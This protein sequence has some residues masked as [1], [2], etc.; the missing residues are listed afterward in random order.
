MDCGPSVLNWK[1]T[2]HCP[3]SPSGQHSPSPVAAGCFHVWGGGSPGQGLGPSRGSEL[4]EGGSTLDQS[5]LKPSQVKG[6]QG[7]G[8][9]RLLAAAGPVLVRGCRGSGCP[10]WGP[11]AISPVLSPVAL[12]PV[13][14]G[15]ISKLRAVHRASPCT[16]PRPSL[17]SRK[18]LRVHRAP[19][20]LTPVPALSFD[21][22][23]S[24]TSS[25]SSGQREAA[26]GLCA[27]CPLN[28]S[29][30]LK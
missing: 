8:A 23:L 14:T 21:S 15:L 9:G 27:S 1:V 18:R 13:A 2:L 28:G 25:D 26:L 3:R 20:P 4:L 22:Y 10:T 11:A 24:W 5:C 19:P 17:I 16:R 7:K 6:P 30:L 29:F 12:I